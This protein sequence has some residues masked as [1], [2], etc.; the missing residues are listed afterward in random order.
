MSS[1]QFVMSAEGTTLAYMERWVGPAQ[2][3]HDGYEISARNTA[4]E[5]RVE[6]SGTPSIEQLISTLHVFGVESESSSLPVMLIDLRGLRT[7]YS[8]LELLHIG[9]E[10]TCSFAHLR[11]LA[12]LVLPQ[13]VTRISE[14]EARRGGID[15]KVFD[16]EALALEWLKLRG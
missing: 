8:R 6:V 7:V 13:D 9:Y 16:L 12:L 15:M 3:A 14:R 2:A 11:R 10:I 5:M 1:S 4:S